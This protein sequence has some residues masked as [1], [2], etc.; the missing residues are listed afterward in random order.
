MAKIDKWVH[1]NMIP[2]LDPRS[3]TA[4]IDHG[5][6]PVE[7]LEADL[8]TLGDFGFSESKARRIQSQREQAQ[9][10]RELRRAAELDIEILCRESSE[11]PARLLD[12]PD[13]PIV[14]YRQGVGRPPKENRFA[15]V[16]ARACTAYGQ[17]Q[18]RRFAKELASRG[19]VI[20]SGLALGTDSAAHRGALDAKGVTLAILGS[21][22]DRIYPREHGPLAQRIS[23]TGTLLSEFPLGT[24][25]RPHH[26]PRRNRII[27]GLSDGVLI[28]EAAKKSGSLLTADFALDQGRDVY[29]LPGSVTSPFTEGTHALIRE[30]AS[31]V[32]CPEHILESHPN[33]AESTLLPGTS[34]DQPR[35]WT[36]HPGPSSKREPS[37]TGERGKLFELIRARPISLPEL[38]SYSALPPSSVHRFL[39]ELELAGWVSRSLDGSFAATDQARRVGIEERRGKKLRKTESLINEKKPHCGASIEKKREPG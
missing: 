16:G 26:F 3:L 18:A 12:L 9:P 21:G 5:R 30:G 25:P 4:W 35:P 2:S 27:S 37:L 33:W 34:K 22:L 7:I 24:S 20:V 36:S 1:L 19:I 6:D 38:V 28:V 13:P 17:S 8:K 11:Y 15:I 10:E 39:T 31:L 29:C 14:L 32:T 23:Q